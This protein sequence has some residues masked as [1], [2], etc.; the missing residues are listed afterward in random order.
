[1]FLTTFLQLTQLT[2]K[3]G[4]YQRPKLLQVLIQQWIMI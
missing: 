3:N 4:S 1:M 2:V